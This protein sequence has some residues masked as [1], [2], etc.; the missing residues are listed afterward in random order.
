MTDAVFTT[1]FEARVLPSLL[2]DGYRRLA[3]LHYARV[4]GD[5]CQ[6][7]LVA[8]TPHPPAFHVEYTSLLLVEPHAFASFD[9]GG[10]CP[11]VDAYP[12]SPPDLDRGLDALLMNYLSQ[13]RPR[14]QASAELPGLM[15][16]TLRQLGESGSP[17]LWFTLAVGHARLGDET[18][19][20]RFAQEALIR[21]RAAGE[22][23][24]D[25]SPNPNTPWAN[26][27]RQRAESL[28]DAL[29]AGRTTALLE[30]WRSGT[31]VALGL[32]SSARWGATTTPS[33]ER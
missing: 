15:D 28:V 9:L 14:L 13:L 8:M 25:G 20:R 33:Q 29:Y 12:A 18:K 24:P 16:A 17:H 5:V 2:V 7:L 11:E 32:D 10:R 23:N 30:G 21:Y 26:K 6:L 1:A 4:V 27:G 31:L 19:A 22:P 3:P